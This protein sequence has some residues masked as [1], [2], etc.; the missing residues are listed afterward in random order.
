[1]KPGAGPLSVE[2]V[3]RV[4][5]QLKVKPED[6]SEME[7]R[8]AGREVAFEADSDDEEAYAPAQWLA[9]NPET[10]PSRVLEAKQNERQEAAGLRLALEALDARSRRIVEARWLKEKDAATPHRPR[11]RGSSGRT[12]A[13]TWPGPRACRAR[14][15]R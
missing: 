2:E 15:R 14:D 13:R 5:A 1:M 11:G 7:M 6:V 12:P 3:G 10:E 8:L 9:A 4:A